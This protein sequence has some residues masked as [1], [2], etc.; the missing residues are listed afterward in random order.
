MTGFLVTFLRL[1]H[2]L[3]SFIF[4]L[5]T[6]VMMKCTHVLKTKTEVVQRELLF[7]NM[8]VNATQQ[9]ELRRAED[10]GVSGDLHTF[11]D[12]TMMLKLLM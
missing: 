9:K 8:Y 6:I 4:V 10:P 5:S 3:C 2:I 7:I 11:I 1:A 12:G